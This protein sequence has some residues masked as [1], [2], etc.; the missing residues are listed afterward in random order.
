[1]RPE[2]TVGEAP[3]AAAP[4]HARRATA[5]AVAA[6]V[7]IAIAVLFRLYALGRLPGVNG[8]EA[9]YG[10]QKARTNEWVLPRFD[11]EG[12]G[13]RVALRVWWTPAAVDPLRATAAGSR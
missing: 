5:L 12:A 4:V 6:G 11:V 13:G 10:V 7:A 2:T 9:W 1:M 8:D 3:A